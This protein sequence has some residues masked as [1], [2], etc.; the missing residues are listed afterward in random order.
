MIFRFKQFEVIHQ[1]SAM[2]VG[3]DGVLLGA[4]ANVDNAKKALDIGAGTGLIS[5]MLAQ[6]NTNLSIDA[7]E[8]DEASFREMEMNF[9]NSAWK[10][11]LKGY[12]IDIADFKSTNAYD[13]IVSNPPFFN[14][15][16][17]SPIL[18]RLN[19][20]H[21]Q[22]LPQEILIAVVNRLLLPFGK[23][24]I[25]LPTIEG[26]QLIEACKKSNLFTTRKTYFIPKEGRKTERLLLEFQ[27]K[28]KELT[29][30][31]IIQY[32]Q[33]NEWHADYI[34]L[35]KDFYLKL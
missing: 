34:A 17:Q 21:N 32:N 28:Q 7:V 2:K 4:W 27:K 10:K 30:N 16:T 18:N 3:T 6:R 12:C 35:T 23:F 33:K 13:L 26:E 8:I 5:L 29:E 25:I 14:L 11:R 22:S 31:K 9:D 20:R 1:H 24:C 15:G 19:A